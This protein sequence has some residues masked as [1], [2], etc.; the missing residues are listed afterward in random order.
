MGKSRYSDLKIVDGKHY[1]TF[2][3]P[4]VSN[5]M[6]T[7]DY[8]AGVKTKE[9]V[10]QVGDRLDHLAAKMF[11]DDQYWWVIALVNDVYYPFTSGGVEPG[12]TLRI[13]LDVND[14]LSKIMR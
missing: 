7:V 2:R 6:K 12:T 1:E 13:P 3:V 8:L 5:G 10:Y 11:G 14:V 4:V 9:Y